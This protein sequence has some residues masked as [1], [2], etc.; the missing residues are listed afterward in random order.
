M[1]LCYLTPIYYVYSHYAASKKQSVSNIICDE[2]CQNTI[3]ICMLFMGVGTLLYELERNDFRSFCSILVLLFSLYGVILINPDLK[4][5]FLFA[6]VVFVDICIFMFLH[7]EKDK[8]NILAAATFLE[9]L[10]FCYITLN[11]QGDIFY[12]EVAYILNFAFYYLYLHFIPVA[13]APPT[14]PPSKS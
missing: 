6:F 7:V 14:T 8:N 3:F 5:H 12:A 11:I 2:K 4:I 10:I 9:L 1:L 13:G